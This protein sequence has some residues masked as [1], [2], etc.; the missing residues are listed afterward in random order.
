MAEVGEAT[1][2]QAEVPG[3]R[4]RGRHQNHSRR[5]SHPE[6][7]KK[8][9]ALKKKHGELRKL[10]LGATIGL[11]VLCFFL[12]GWAFKATGNYRKAMHSRYLESEALA[13]AQ[14]EIEATKGELAALVENR[15]PN[16]Q[17]FVADEVIPNRG[18][19]V[20]FAARRGFVLTGHRL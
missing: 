13:T 8:Y 10:F 17:P 16:L 1:Q 5:R 4:P 6:L 19:E 15:I 2:D 3:K 12:G 20:R 9:L 7:T 14:A 11:V 18:V